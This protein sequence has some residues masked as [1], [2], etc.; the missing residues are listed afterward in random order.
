MHNLAIMKARVIIQLRD[1][2]GWFFA[3]MKTYTVQTNWASVSFV[4]DTK[5]TSMS[6]EDTN[7]EASINVK[8][9]HCP[10][11]NSFLIIT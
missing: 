3:Y 8:I 9:K 5:L 6:P 7:M 2:V 1:N 10:V 11:I 4:T